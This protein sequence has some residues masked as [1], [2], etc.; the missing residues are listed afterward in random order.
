MTNPEELP[1][2]KPETP[3]L[4]A[5]DALKP[6]IARD[7]F[8]QINRQQIE[9]E[10]GRLQAFEAAEQQ[11]AGAARIELARRMNCPELARLRELETDSPTMANIYREANSFALAQ[12]E[13]RIAA[14]ETPPDDGPQA[15]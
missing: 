11:G 3:K 14:L 10:T 13:R 7:L 9:I 15:A 8:H 4:D 12:Q 6:G 2:Q 1:M 5:L